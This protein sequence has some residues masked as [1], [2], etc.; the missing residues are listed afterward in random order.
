MASAGAG[1]GLTKDTSLKAT[2]GGFD[3]ASFKGYA[4]VTTPD[5]TF[6]PKNLMTSA[7]V[8]CSGTRAEGPAPDF[9]L[10][11]GAAAGDDAASP[12]LAAVQH[13]DDAPDDVKAD[14]TKLRELLADNSRWAELCDTAL[15]SVGDEVP[16]ADA[17]AAALTAISAAA[18]LDPVDAEEASE[19]FLPKLTPVEFQHLCREYFQSLCRTLDLEDDS[20]DPSAG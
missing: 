16:D 9:S 18:G 1:A 4:T 2:A 17:L 12:P 13:M 20:I 7:H 3:A 10:K 15:R 6:G 5:A 11:K 19:M 8:I 14:P